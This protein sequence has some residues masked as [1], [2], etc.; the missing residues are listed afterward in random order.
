[1]PKST[2]VVRPSIVIARPGHH[3]L[4]RSAITRHEVNCNEKEKDDVE[5]QAARDTALGA[6]WPTPIEAWPQRHVHWVGA[7]TWGPDPFR[8]CSIRLSGM[9]F[10]SMVSCDSH[11][12]EE[13]KPLVR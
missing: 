10:H 11:A 9:H 4:C 5:P 2:G 8:N 1:M 7:A 3:S 13:H 12:K 6:S